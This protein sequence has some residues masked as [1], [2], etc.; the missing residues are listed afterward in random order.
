MTP[1]FEPTR[2]AALTRLSDFL[3]HTG[4]DY[5]SL[6]NYDLPGHPHVSGLSP[7]I[8]HRLI[9]EEEVLQATLGRFSLSTAEKFVQEVYWRT[10]WK[11]WL[12]MRPSVWTMYQSGVQAQW[13]RVQTEGGL[14]REWEAACR[15]DT[16]IECFDHW[17]NE[18]TST[19]YLHNHARMWF[20]SIWIFTLG[21]PWEL[22]ADF[23][24]RHLLDGDAASNT[25]GWRW[26]AGLQTAGK[27]YLARTS[28]I[29]KF[30]KERFRPQYQL[31]GD[32]PAVQG[33]PNPDRT[34]L[35]LADSLDTSVPTVLILTDDDL[36]PGFLLDRGLSPVATAIVPAHKRRSPLEVADH[37]PEFFTAAAKDVTERYGARLGPVETVDPSN[38][39]NWA[40][41]HGADHIVT[42]YT[43]IGWTNDALSQAT[44]DIPLRRIRR[45]YDESAWP[46]ATAGFFKFKEKIPRLVGEIKGLKAA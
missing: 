41:S 4:R 34:P 20:A 27:T 36:S 11:G 16:G 1:T 22:G 44:G 12:E 29:A 23:F 30:T 2:T 40:A 25:L 33:F 17:A 31:A 10:Y 5:A 24:L 28:N 8:K 37:I 7:Y 9:T 15:G 18:L 19:G 38:L 13:N 14:R 6:R 26:V 21:L 35:P 43:P 46:F 32:A 45:S 39:Q 42:A 3:P